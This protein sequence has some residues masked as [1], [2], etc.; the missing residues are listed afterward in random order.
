MVVLL[1]TILF[2]IL[3]IFMELRLNV[4]HRRHTE[5]IRPIATS[6][7]GKLDGQLKTFIRILFFV[8]YVISV[9]LIVIII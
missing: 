5:K 9:L 1:Y 2:A 8:V 4:L 6:G 7:L 3:V